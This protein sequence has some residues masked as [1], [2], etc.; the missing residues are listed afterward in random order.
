M[1]EKITYYFLRYAEPYAWRTKM[2]RAEIMSYV[3]TDKAHRNC[4]EAS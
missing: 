1:I 2:M 3:S 4:C